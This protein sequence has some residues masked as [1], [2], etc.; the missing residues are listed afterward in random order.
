MC[1][2]DSDVPQYGEPPETSWAVTARGMRP[3]SVPPVATV[4]ARPD[5]GPSRFGTSVVFVAFLPVS[6]SDRR[7][8]VPHHALLR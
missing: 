7:R 4:P 8:Y 2:A 6:W 1:C 3:T 5:V